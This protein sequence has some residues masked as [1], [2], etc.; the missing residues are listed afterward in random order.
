M[1]E[2]TGFYFCHIPKT[3]GD[4]IKKLCEQLK[5]P[6]IKIHDVDD[7]TKHAYIYREGKDFIMS[8]RRLPYHA[9][10]LYHEMRFQTPETVPELDCQGIGEWALEGC[11]AE[12]LATV[13]TNKLANIPDYF[14]RSETLRSDL[15]V[16]LGRYY[17]LGSERH[18]IIHEGTTKKTW[19]YNRDLINYFTKDQIK[20]LYRQ[21]PSWAQ[22][23]QQAYGDNLCDH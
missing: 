16:V 3:G 13:Y 17:G 12:G 5:L 20:E 14:V 8:I 21:A 9:L 1:I 18:R 7:G 2:G 11:H 4:A 22:L 10:S 15:A 6:K 23:E 19:E